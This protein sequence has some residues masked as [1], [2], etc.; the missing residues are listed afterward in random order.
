MSSGTDIPILKLDEE[1]IE[2]WRVAIK[3]VFSNTELAD[4]LC[5]LAVKGL[6][7][8]LTSDSQNGG[9]PE[10]TPCLGCGM[11]LRKLRSYFGSE[12]QKD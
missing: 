1:G 7:S 6:Q 10:D 4:A 5:D 12:H 9:S 3:R 2:R 8:A 11:T